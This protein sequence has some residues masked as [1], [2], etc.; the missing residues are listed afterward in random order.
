MS[1]N[2]VIRLELLEKIENHLIDYIGDSS[3]LGTA[4]LLEQ[5][6]DSK[7]NNLCKMLDFVWDNVEG[8]NKAH[9][10]D[11]EQIHYNREELKEKI[12]SLPFFTTFHP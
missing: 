2:V 3:Y 12:N 1:N 9:F 5:I 6:R 11:F 10:E 4:Q 7:K 8:Y